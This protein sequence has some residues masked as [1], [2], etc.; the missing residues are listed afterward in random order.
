[1]NIPLVQGKTLATFI[2]KIIIEN[3][4][5]EV[6]KYLSGDSVNQECFREVYFSR[7]LP[8]KSK[9]WK[10]NKKQS[11]NL[12]SAVG[13]ISVICIQ[14]SADGYTYEEFLLDDEKHFGVLEVPAGIIY[15]LFADMQGAL[16]VNS[17]REAY[18]D[19]DAETITDVFDLVPT[20]L[21]TAE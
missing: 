11:Q 3:P 7:L 14:K 20:L 8:G 21:Y 9:K 10:C 17:L 15:G 19:S 5:G 6:R 12:T 2:P 4:S 16:I 13:R 18:S 1:M